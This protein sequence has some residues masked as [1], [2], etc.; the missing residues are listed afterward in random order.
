MTFA[1]RSVALG[2][3]FLVPLG[4]WK[5]RKVWFV[6]SPLGEGSGCPWVQPGQRPRV[7]VVSSPQP[8]LWALFR[9]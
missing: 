4:S 1:G 7:P 8:G 6:W 3:G 9:L 5:C 2:V